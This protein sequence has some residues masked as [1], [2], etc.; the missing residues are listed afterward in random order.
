[1][2]PFRLSIRGMV[3]LIAVVGFDLAVL[4]RAYQHGRWAGSVSGYLVGFGLVLLLFNVI[5]IRLA[6][7]F[8]RVKALP[9]ARLLATRVSP[10]VML[11]IYLAV[12]AIP[13]LAILFYRPGT[14]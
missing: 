4:V 3:G 14:F 11:A 7:S 10:S 8:A 2:E 9:T 6:L 13:I 1:M 5:L 12:L